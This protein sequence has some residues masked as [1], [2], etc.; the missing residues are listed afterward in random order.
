MSVGNK[1]LEQSRTEKRKPVAWQ[2]AKRGI[3]PNLAILPSCST[4]T[5]GDFEKRFPIEIHTICALTPPC[6]TF[7]AKATSDLQHK[8]ALCLP[9]TTLSRSALR[10]KV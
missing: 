7:P 2:V 6:T 5:V 8:L 3:S 10:G 1:D 4:R 9:E